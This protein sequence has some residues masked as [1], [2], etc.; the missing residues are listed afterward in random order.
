MACLGRN[1]G[2]RLRADLSAGGLIEDVGEKLLLRG[3]WGGKIFNIGG[4]MDPYVP[5]AWDLIWVAAFRTCIVPHVSHMSA[6]MSHTVWGQV[7]LWMDQDRQCKPPRLAQP[8]APYAASVPG[9]KGVPVNRQAP[10][11]APCV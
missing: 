10:S 8:G 3:E 7:L 5:L 9:I 1:L 11:A 2:A 4:R 6:P